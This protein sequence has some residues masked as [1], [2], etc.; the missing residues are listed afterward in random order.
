MMAA[1]RRAKSRFGLPA[2]LE[3]ETRRRPAR[4]ADLIWREVASLLL[5]KV[6]DPAVLPVTIVRVEVSPD[7]KKAW[8]YFVCSD[9][10]IKKATQGLNRARGFMRSH[11]A[12][13][14][15]MRSV[16]ELRFLYDSEQGQ[17]EKMD[18]LFR[19]IEGEI[20]D[21]SSNS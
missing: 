16:P 17:R 6:K 18:N 5:H 1:E 10:E 20:A 15:Q 11:L 14:T 12:S 13:I 19:E 7:L 4:V 3:K 2:G 21:S 8:I 9:S